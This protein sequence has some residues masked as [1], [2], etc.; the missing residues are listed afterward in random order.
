MTC[1]STILG[2]LLLLCR[3]IRH[4]VLRRLWVRTCT[5][6]G[7]GTTAEQGGH[8]GLSARSQDGAVTECAYL[9]LYV[10]AN[11]PRVGT[12]KPSW[13]QRHHAELRT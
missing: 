9:V 2:T 12:G 11:K 8:D 6:R 3:R 7:C 10:H 1:G 5:G 4:S 13:N